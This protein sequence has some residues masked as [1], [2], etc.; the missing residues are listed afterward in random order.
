MVNLLFFNNESV[1]RF[2]LFLLFFV[3]CSS[4]TACKNFEEGES[5]YYLKI[6]DGYFPVPIRY[7]LNIS[8]FGQEE[9]L[10]VLLESPVER[11]SDLSPEEKDCSIAHNTG[12]IHAGNFSGSVTEKTL[13]G[14]MFLFRKSKLYGLIIRFLKLKSGSAIGSDDVVV[15]LISN[16]LSYLA[17]VDQNKDL[18]LDLLDHYGEFN[19]I[20]RD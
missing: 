1:S 11:F 5:F 4:A 18:W 12:Y 3:S 19:N 17:I 6:F 16:E 7:A 9:K 2:V 8:S 14:S 10:E 20:T 15:V 13:M